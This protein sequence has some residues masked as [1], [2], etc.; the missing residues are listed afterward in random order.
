MDFHSLKTS[1]IISGTDF[2]KQM[3]NPA[4]GLLPFAW[5]STSEPTTRPPAPPRWGSLSGAVSGLHRFLSLPGCWH[6]GLVSPCVRGPRRGV[7]NRKW[8]FP[9][10]HTLQGPRA[11]TRKTGPAQACRHWATAL[12][13]LEPWSE[14]SVSGHS[15]LLQV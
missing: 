8:G 6:A 2:K 1:S 14:G 9:G 12:R 5:S 10:P 15:S 11:A 3:N 13:R 4:S 7:H